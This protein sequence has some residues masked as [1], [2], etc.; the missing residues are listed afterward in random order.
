MG[1]CTSAQA[2]AEETEEKL[3]EDKERDRCIHKI[4]LLG[5]GESGKSTIFKQIVSMYRDGFTDKERASYTLD[6]RSTLLWSM[7]EL[8]YQ[9]E[10]VYGTKDA[11][12]R[13]SKENEEFVTILNELKG[14]EKEKHSPKVF[15][16]IQNLWKDKAVQA[17]FDLRD[18]FQIE[19]ATEY[20]MNKVDK[21]GDPGYI[22]SEDDI[23]R[24]H[25]RTNGVVE[26]KANPFLIVDVGGQRAARRKWIHSFENVSCIIFVAAISAYNQV[27]FEDNKTNR[28]E[29]SLTLFEEICNSRWFDRASIV[30]FLNKSDLFREKIERY[31]ITECPA[32]R[33][34]PGDTTDFNATTK[35]V[36]EEFLL[37]NQT[38]KTVFSHIT[39][40]TDKTNVT[41]VFN[42]VKDTVLKIS[43]ERAGLVV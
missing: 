22:P 6:I 28:L 40:A 14:E 5:A 35:F 3:E 16:A 29:E 32:L 38:P 8:L 43:L 41:I 10:N 11:K 33:E 27:L 23:L 24:I 18:N 26:F 13:I 17:V 20:F 30:L 39:C 15:K 19:V 12:Y 25:I 4:L 31:P 7:K 21:L 9:I 37:K 2:S 34:F 36:E 42:S 1:I